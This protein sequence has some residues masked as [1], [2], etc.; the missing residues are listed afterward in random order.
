MALRQSGRFSVINLQGRFH[1]VNLVSIGIVKECLPALLTK[2]F[3]KLY[4]SF[5]V[6]DL[7]V[8]QQ[9]FFFSCPP[10][11]YKYSLQQI[12]SI[13]KTLI[14]FIKSYYTRYNHCISRHICILTIR[15]F[16]LKPSCKDNLFL[17]IIVSNIY[18]SRHK[19]NF[20]NCVLLIHGT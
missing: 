18:L 7:L 14:N 16:R 19:S 3:I 12:G 2:V 11:L 17:E 6:Y 8:N 15:L 4:Q 13:N 10:A 20:K 1:E 9:N 5:R